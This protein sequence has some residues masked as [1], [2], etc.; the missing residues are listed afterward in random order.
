[1]M[2]IFQR[3]GETERSRVAG[4]SEYVGTAMM[5]LWA[6]Q[7]KVATQFGLVSQNF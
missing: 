5:D 6:I 7:T 1:M 2:E 4:S 3:Y